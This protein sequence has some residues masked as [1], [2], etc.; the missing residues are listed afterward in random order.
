MPSGE[1]SSL[2]HSEFLQRVSTLGFNS[3]FEVS[4]HHMITDP[5]SSVERVHFYLPYMGRDDDRQT[6]TLVNL[7]YAATCAPEV[8]AVAPHL[9]A[10]PLTS[11]QLRYD[12]K[13]LRVGFVSKFFGDFEPHGLLLE[14]IIRHLPRSHFHTVL[15]PISA[16]EKGTAPYLLDAADEVVPLSL[17][18][19]HARSVLMDAKLDVLI[20]ADMNSEPMT[21][22]LGYARFA[23]VQ[24]LFWGNPI[25]SGSPAIDYF[26]S[27]DRMED[28]HRTMSSV[29]PYSEQFVLLD[30]QG[31]WYSKFRDLE[32]KYYTRTGEGSVIQQSA[33]STHQDFGLSHDDLKAYDS[34]VW[35]D[36]GA[37]LQQMRRLRE[38]AEHLEHAIALNPDNHVS[39]NNLGV[40]L[41]DLEQPHEALAW[42]LRAGDGGQLS[43][44][45]NAANIYR[46]AGDF[47]SAF[48]LICTN[49]FGSEACGSDAESIGVACVLA[50][51]GCLGSVPRPHREGLRCLLPPHRPHRA[52]PRLRLRRGSVDHPQD[53]ARQ[54]L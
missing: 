12:L 48:D 31:I 24:A 19:K 40:T 49:L 51:G 8:R 36:M 50:L 35:S 16:P 17:S 41:K 1:A 52:D 6:Q 33:L 53:G 7:M 46:D 28:P 37:V 47:R 21:H 10:D 54:G 43:A 25:T 42:F 4:P 20:F 38:S 30:G 23:S 45:E 2:A 27:A 3:A 34:N 15:F 9:P 44:I 39:M 18:Y 11:R 32:D 26:I 13:P 29:E 5:V 14:G 22:F